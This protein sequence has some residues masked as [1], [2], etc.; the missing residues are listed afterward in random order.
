MTEISPNQKSARTARIVGI[1]GAVA[2][3]A[4]AAWASYVVK[5]HVSWLIMLLAAFT[6]TF[7]AIGCELFVNHFKTLDRESSESDE[8]GS[9][10][11]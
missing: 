8:A 10:G 2:I 9:D 6:G 5:G 4:L 7:H 1:G 3:I 11:A